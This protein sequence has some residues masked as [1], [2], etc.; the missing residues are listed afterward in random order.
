MKIIFLSCSLLLSAMAFAQPRV[1]ENAV[2]STNT[3]VIAPEEEDVSQIQGQGSGGGFNMRNMGDGETKSTTYI[4]KD[5]VKTLYKSEMGR[6]TTYRNN[7]TKSTTSI[8]EM[9]GNKTGIVSNDEDQA[10]IVRRTDSMMKERSKTDTALR[11]R[12]IRTESL[13][14]SIVYTEESKKIA[15]FNCKKAFI[16]TDRILAKDSMIVWYT[17]DI[18]FPNVSSTG[19]LS[20]LGSMANINGFDKVDGFI[21]QYERNMAR[22][23][24]MEVKVTKIEMDKE[25]ADK[26]FDLPKDIEIRNIKEMRGPGGG[27]GFQFQMR[28]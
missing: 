10:D 13:P 16:V 8:I 20:G 24:K 22:G 2:I 12:R 6:I 26:E 28:P 19:G 9:M 15:G 27:G 21:M 5:L 23:R 7:T 17:P 4:K 11:G 18:K 14:V 25:I 3:N 1:I